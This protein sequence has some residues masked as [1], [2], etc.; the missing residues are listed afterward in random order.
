MGGSNGKGD[1]RG[2][3]QGSDEGRM[4]REEIERDQLGTLRGSS[5]GRDA[6]VIE[7]DEMIRLGH[8]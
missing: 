7:I 8:G 5:A 2:L 3:V 1:A 4:A 6:G